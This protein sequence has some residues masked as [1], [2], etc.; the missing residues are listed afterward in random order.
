MKIIIWLC[1]S[2]FFLNQCFAAKHYCNPMKGKMSN[3]GAF[4]SP[5]S[6]LDSVFLTSK[7]LMPGDSIIL[8]SGNHGQPIISGNLNGDQPITIL[9][10]KGQFPRVNNLQVSGGRY[11]K[12]FGLK[13]CPDE[14]GSFEKRDFVIIKASSSFILI[15]NFNI[16]STDS[17]VNNW[18]EVKILARAGLGISVEGADCSLINNT[19]KQV[20]FGIVVAK[21]ATRT[22]VIGNNIYG[23][24]HDGIRGLSDDSLFEFNL[25]AGSYGIDDNHDDGFQS[26]SSDE[27]GKVGMGKVSNVILRNNVFISQLD[28]EQ[29]F[30]QKTGMQGIGCFDGFFENWI[31]ENNVVLTNM[32]HGISFY[33]ARNV[34]IVNNTVANNPFTGKP[35]TPWIGIYSHKKLGTGS[36]NMVQENF[37]TGISELNGVIN[38]SGNIKA[39]V[40]SLNEYLENWESFQIGIKSNVKKR[41][42]V[43]ADTRKLPKINLQLYQCNK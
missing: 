3:E 42:K 8:M 26:W 11:W 27:Q 31:V 4:D 19:L 40:H 36:G 21:T 37:T 24:L 23:F 32:W 7:A 28:P 39:A 20:S 2:V 12:I 22:K 16:S 38:E 18:S 29:P 25:V 10:G 1:V 41:N 5:W 43:G 13:I 33:G 9:P 15:E 34:K 6:T 35:F 14:T 30:P 17:C